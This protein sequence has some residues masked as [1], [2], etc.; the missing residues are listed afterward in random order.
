[1]VVG[2]DAGS[3]LVGCKVVGVSVGPTLGNDAGS[4]VGCKVGVSVGPTLGELAGGCED[5][6][7]LVD[8][9]LHLG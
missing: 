8:A 3:P 1:V 6:G 9:P 4:L 2:N 7:Q 5:V